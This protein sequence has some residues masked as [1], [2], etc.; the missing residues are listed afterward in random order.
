[1]AKV[2]LTPEQKLSAMSMLRSRFFIFAHIGGLMI[3]LAT[4]KPFFGAHNIPAGII[5]VL[6]I[7]YDHWITASKKAKRL[8]VYPMLLLSIWI[9]VNT[10]H[11]F[12]MPTPALTDAA[13][14]LGFIGAILVVV[15]FVSASREIRL[16]D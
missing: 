9:Q 15:G 8:I 4:F 2:V 7:V 12:V 5:L 3:A 14:K 1:M 10:L 13:I 6:S 16:M 11:S